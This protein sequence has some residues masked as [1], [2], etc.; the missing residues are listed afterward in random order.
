[1]ITA[2]D[3]G[4]ALS[5]GRR[6]SA[7]EERDV[8]VD[9]I[10]ADRNCAPPRVF[11]YVAA[12]RIEISARLIRICRLVLECRTKCQVTIVAHARQ[13]RVTTGRITLISAGLR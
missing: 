9:S 5:P 13:P 8:G 2:G 10:P 11:H 6:N 7:V 1:M 4:G 3:W 12:G